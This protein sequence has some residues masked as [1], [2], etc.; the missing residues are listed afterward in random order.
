[1]STQ[2]T[3]P[4]RAAPRASLGE[5]T[6][7]ALILGLA[8]YHLAL[9][10]F[11]VLAPGPFFDNVGPFGERNDHYLRDNATINLA[12]A[13][14]LF[15]AARRASWRIPVLAVVALQY[16]FHLINHILDGWVGPF[17]AISLALLGG[18][19][20]WLWWRSEEER[21]G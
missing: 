2:S 14:A 11:M 9:G 3:R 5:G 21:A 19:V 12:F 18:F 7:R 4:A 17:D 1:M 20:A 16:G 10:L 15:V 6:V 8:A 13:V